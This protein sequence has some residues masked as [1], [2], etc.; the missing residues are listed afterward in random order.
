MI[1]EIPSHVVWALWITA[2]G[3]LADVVIRLIGH[4]SKAALNYA[5]ASEASSQ[6]AVNQEQAK[7]LGQQV[8][9][10]IAAEVREITQD[11]R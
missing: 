7:L 11:Q 10:E 5:Q 1:A 6:A 2:G 9:S 4:R 3:T 8:S